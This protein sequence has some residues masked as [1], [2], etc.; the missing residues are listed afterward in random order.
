MLSYR[1]Q[2]GPNMLSEIA[3]QLTQITPLL[4]SVSPDSGILP[5]WGGRRIAS[6]FKKYID[7]LLAHGP[8]ASV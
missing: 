2:S 6:F 7:L 8:S 3:F 5:D 1:F 4:T